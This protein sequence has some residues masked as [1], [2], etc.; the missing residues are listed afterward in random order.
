MDV[1]VFPTTDVK[2]A[3]MHIDVA[4]LV[5]AFPRQ[6]GM[7]R[8]DLL[9]KNASIFREQGRALNEYASRNVKVVYIIHT[10]YIHLSTIIDLSNFH[11]LLINLSILY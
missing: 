1:E 6:K 11:I 10:F 4:I 8:K 7:E 9:Q 3:F 5:G 2:A